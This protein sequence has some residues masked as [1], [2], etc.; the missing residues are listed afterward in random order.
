MKAKIILTIL[1]FLIGSHIYSA[2]YY[3]NDASTTGDLYCTAV[4]NNSNNGLSPATPKLTLAAVYALAGAG[5]TILIDTGI[6]EGSSNRFVDESPI[7]KVGLQI[8]GAGEDLTVFK[9]GSGEARWLT[10]SANNVKISRMTIT[11]FTG[12]LGYCDGIAIKITGGTGIEL[13][14]ML[15]Y[16]NIGTCG[17]GAVLIEGNSTSVTINKVSSHC[18]RIGSSNYGGGYKINGSTVVFNECTIASNVYSQA[19]G[20]GIKIEGN[21]ANVTINKTI[22][23][24]NEAAGGGGMSI[25]NGTVN[26]NNSCF[27]ENFSSN[28]TGAPGGGAVLIRSTGTGNT[29]L[30]N[31]NN[32][33]FDGNYTSEY[34]SDGGAIIITN[35]GRPTCNVSFTNCSF[36]N[37]SANDK[38]EDIYLDRLLSVSGGFPLFDVVFKNTTFETLYAGTRV[39]LYNQDIAAAQ[40]KFEA[41]AGAGGNGDIVADGSGVAISKPEFSSGIAAPAYT[42]TSSAL[43]VGLPVTFCEDRFIGTCGGGF[44]LFCTKNPVTGASDSALKTNIGFSTLSTIQ[45]ESWPHNIPNGLLVMESKNKGFVLTRMSDTERNSIPT[46]IEG[47]LIYNTTVHCLQIFNGVTW[48][49][50][51]ETCVD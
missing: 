21:T 17:Q 34:Q 9:L 13:S 25:W 49:C 45:S 35:D 10:I 27:K 41:L 12:I 8:I 50:M 28:L 7:N 37:N 16:G 30:V 1:C 40:I 23:E 19:Q 26:I 15:I 6:Y 4:G 46:P 3:L 39:N 32:C 22:F 48:R 42:E 38:G 24:D 18:N 14:N 51:V 31:F 29:T 11:E 5:D 36:K 47:M 33:S 44:K 43:P 2:T 20:G